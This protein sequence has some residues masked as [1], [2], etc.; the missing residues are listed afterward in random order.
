VALFEAVA[1]VN[2][3]DLLRYTYQF[4]TSK[5]LDTSEIVDSFTKDPEYKVPVHHALRALLYVDSLHYDPKAC[6]FINLFDIQRADR[7]EHF[8]RLTLLHYL[9]TQPDVHPTYGFARITD[10]VSHLLK[11]GY[12]SSHAQWTIRYLFERSCV[13]SRDP[14]EAWSDDVKE[15]RPRPLGRYHITDLITHFAY[16]DAIT[17]DTPI[18]EPLIRASI[19]NVFRIGQRI[20]RCVTIM[21]YLNSTANDVVDLLVK[22]LWAETFKTVMEM[23]ARIVERIDEEDAEFGE[24]E[25]RPPSSRRYQ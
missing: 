13:E 11:I 12:S 17:I 4:L 7:L 15:I 8:T 24:A 6:K 5:F 2:T 19:T 3:R 16:F 14:V 25:D 20:E 23:M 9:S 18:L 10:A 1:N 21:E 22:H